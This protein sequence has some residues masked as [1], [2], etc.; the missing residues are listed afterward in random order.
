MKRK[1]STKSL[2]ITII[3]I[4]LVLLV[5]YLLTY[6]PLFFEEETLQ[7]TI[8]KAIR[9]NNPDLCKR[10]PK[11]TIGTTPED[12]CYEKVAEKLQKPELCYKTNSVEY[13]I[14]SV[15]AKNNNL[16]I[17]DILFTEEYISQP[18]NEGSSIEFF[19]R[20]KWSCY[21]EVASGSSNFEICNLIEDKSIKGECF[22]DEA[23]FKEDSSI[24]EK[25][26]NDKPLKKICIGDTSQ[27]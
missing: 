14:S 13:C 1:S 18:F 8:T 11:T 19:Q 6:S 4:L 3:I 15:A 2:I 26:I 9:T 24:C 10:L 12:E 5:S 20:Y 23:K 22:Y 27:E 25:I 21:R 17:C 16:S 7:N